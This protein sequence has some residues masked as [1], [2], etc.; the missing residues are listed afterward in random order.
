MLNEDFTKRLKDENR[1]KDFKEKEQKRLQS[2]PMDKKKWRVER[3]ENRFSG[4][5]IHC[6]HIVQ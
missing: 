5:V 3:I 2:S 4:C 1:G 6:V